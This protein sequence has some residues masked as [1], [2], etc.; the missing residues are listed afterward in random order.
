MNFIV[1]SRILEV[2]ARSI[3]SRGRD[4]MGSQSV[5]ENVEFIPT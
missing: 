5:E 3:S 4:R 1:A 2:M